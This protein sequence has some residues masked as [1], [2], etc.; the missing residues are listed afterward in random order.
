MLFSFFLLTIDIYLLI[1]AVFA[2]IF[3]PTSELAIPIEIT[4]NEA[5]AEIVTNH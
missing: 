5:S 4:T 1:S 3:N 2:Q